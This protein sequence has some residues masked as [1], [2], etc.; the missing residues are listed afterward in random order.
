MPEFRIEGVTPA[1]KPVQG[2]LE[3]ESPRVAK[4]RAAQM[5]QQRNFKLLRVIPRSTWIY[6]VQRGTDKPITGEQKAYSKAEV[7]EALQ[8]MGF[9]VIYVQRRL[10]DFKA[11]PPSTEIVTFVRVS[12]DLIKQRHREPVVA[13]DH[14]G[15]QR[16]AEAGAGQR[17]GL[18]EA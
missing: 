8:R 6:K 5:A 15:H 13:R 2:V 18:P 12:A 3:A 10:F 11:K 4:K 9:R 16:G 14:Q 1:G 7:R 17:E